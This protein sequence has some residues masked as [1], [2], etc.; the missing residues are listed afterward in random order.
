ML[1][2]VKYVRACG[3]VCLCEQ[4][5]QM[6]IGMQDIY[7][8]KYLCIYYNMGV[9]I[10]HMAQ[11]RAGKIV[12]LQSLCMIYTMRCTCMMWEATLHI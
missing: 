1:V 12:P 5:P 2:K 7:T 9:L 3:G 4:K 10:L 6:A 8:N 11:L